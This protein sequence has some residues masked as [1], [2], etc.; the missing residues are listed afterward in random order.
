MIRS[1]LFVVHLLSACPVALGQPYPVPDFADLRIP[2]GHRFVAVDVDFDGD[3]DLVSSDDAYVFHINN[4]GV[5]DET[6]VAQG[7]DPFDMLLEDVDG[8]TDLD[9]IGIVPGSDTVQLLINQGD[10]QYD[11][12]VVILQGGTPRTGSYFDINADGINDTVVSFRNESYI[13]VLPGQGEGVF[14]EEQRIAMT[15]SGKMKHIFTDLDADGDLDLATA[16]TN[17]MVVVFLNDGFGNFE[18]T[19]QYPTCPDLND[20]VAGDVDGDGDADLVLCY[21]DTHPEPGGV[22][23][24]LNTGDASMTPMPEF[25]SDAGPSSMALHDLDADQDLDLVVTNDRTSSASIFI[26]DGNA[27]FS[28]H[29]VLPTSDRPGFV[30]I[31]DVN[32]DGVPEIGVTSIFRTF[33]RPLDLFY[34]NGDLGYG[35]TRIQDLTHRPYDMITLDL[36]AD[37]YPDVIQTSSGNVLSVFLSDTNGGVIFD[38]DYIIGESPRIEPPIDLNGDGILDIVTSNQGGLTTVSVL[39]GTNTG[40]LVQFDEFVLQRRSSCSAFLDLDGDG[41]LDMVTMANSV[42]RIHI[43]SNDGNIGFTY[44]GEIDTGG[45]RPSVCRT[46]DIDNDGIEELLVGYSQSSSAQVFR[47]DGALGLVEGPEFALPSTI[48]VMELS[49]VDLDGDLDPVYIIAGRIGVM[50]NQSDGTLAPVELYGAELSS[51]ISI[52]LNDLNGDGY[53]DAVVGFERGSVLQVL[54]NDGAGA[55]EETITLPS[56]GTSFGLAIDDIDRDGD[57]DLVASN[58]DLRTL[59]VHPNLRV[60]AS[61]PADFNADGS[62]DFFDVTEFIQAFND[63]DASADLNDDGLF[64]FFDVSAFLVAYGEGCP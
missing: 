21:M 2:S 56:R 17:N 64:D 9:I 16:E 18:L 49:D 47:P 60:R 30:R 55:F 25:I 5:Y 1:S 29:K 31:F 4:N 58:S 27:Q 39:L 28:L 46:L 54:I 63:Q 22:Q 8:D 42:D 57:N 36:N 33:Q 26:N 34:A 41:D 43:Y 48:R 32:L 52:A 14:G 51:L 59:S 6:L 45:K 13:S 35:Q 44:T 24:L 7:Q 53:P 40:T 11:S 3:L 23:V 15:S 12:P 61:C 50:R 62:L 20:L 10:L 19:H 38:R 37:T